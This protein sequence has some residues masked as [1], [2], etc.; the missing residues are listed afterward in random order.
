LLRHDLVYR[1]KK[2]LALAGLE[3]TLAMKDREARLQ[4]LA[5]L[6]SAGSPR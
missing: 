5:A 4:E 6:A 2:I 1:W 3:P